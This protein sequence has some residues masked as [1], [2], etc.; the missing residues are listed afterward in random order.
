MI[1]KQ[2]NV[3]F[4][5]LKGL[6]C[7]LIVFIHR[8]FPGLI[9]D[10]ISG[11]ARSGVA[12][13]FISSGFYTYYENDNIILQQLP[14]KISHVKRIL[15]GALLFYLIWESF[16][17]WYGS[18]F[19]S[20]YNWI[21]THVID[22]KTWYK[23]LVWDYD[24]FAGHLWFLFALLRCYLLFY[25]MVKSK[26][27]RYAKICSA[28][29]MIG[30]LVLQKICADMLYYR[31]GWLYGLGFFL[32]GY[33]LAENK[34]KMLKTENGCFWIAVGVIVTIIECFISKKQQMYIGTIITAVNSFAIT[35]KNPSVKNQVVSFFALLGEKYS[36]LIYIVHWSIKEIF[37][38]I[39]KMVA[40]SMDNWYL[41]ISPI[42]LV[43]MSIVMSFFVRQIAIWIN[44]ICILIF[45][46]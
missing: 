30:V 40:F 9:G 15:I 36:M 35:C 3:K 45:L 1:V 34:E 17:R 44:K 10:I 14:H 39:D 20:M 38:K 16:I 7:V 42:A 6:A 27:L 5:A 28:V 8:P 32:M 24:P 13:F 43:F 41:W 37:I 26:L 46:L 22:V 31:N 23:V 19:A 18:G 4:D 2:R 11:I 29:C 25:I 21:M 12:V 33:L